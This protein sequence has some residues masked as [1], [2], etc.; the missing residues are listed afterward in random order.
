M[1]R[2]NA[3]A[4]GGELQGPGL[5]DGDTRTLPAFDKHLT[6]MGAFGEI[7]LGNW[8]LESLKLKQV[9]CVCMCLPGKVNR[10]SSFIS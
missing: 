2:F 4:Q 9:C 1:L 6:G 8:V 5:E 3:R 7:L 10:Q